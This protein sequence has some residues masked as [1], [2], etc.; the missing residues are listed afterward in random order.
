MIMYTFLEEYDMSGKT[1]IPF[2]TH[3]GSGWGSSLSELRTLCPGA[4][5]INGFSTAG[6]NARNAQNDVRTWLSGLDIQSD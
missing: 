2:S 1:I 5:F 6:T 4:E 3:G